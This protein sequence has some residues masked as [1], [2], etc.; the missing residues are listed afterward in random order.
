MTHGFSKLS[1]RV[2]QLFF[3]RNFASV[4][5]IE[6]SVQMILFLLPCFWKVLKLVIGQGNIV[7]DGFVFVLSSCHTVVRDV[8]I[9]QR[10]GFQLGH[11]VESTDALLSGNPGGRE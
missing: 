1:R 5:G 6:N 2:K 8:D 7:N 9:S 10:C 3:I 11:G 4:D